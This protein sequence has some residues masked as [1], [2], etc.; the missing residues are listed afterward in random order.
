MQHHALAPARVAH[1]VQRILKNLCACE[2]PHKVCAPIHVKT[3]IKTNMKTKSSPLSEAANRKSKIE[4][5]KFGSDLRPAGQPLRLC[6]CMFGH[7]WML[8]VGFSMLVLGC[9]ALTDSSPTG[10]R[11]TRSSLGANTSLPSLALEV[12]TNGLRRVELRRY[13]PAPRESAENRQLI[14]L[15]HGEL[16]FQLFIKN[17]S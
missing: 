2:T 6:R 13:A 15:N 14:T 16:H 11:F 17:Y 10:E 1:L 4:H 3:E 7:S 8:V 9:Q 5:Q 12:N